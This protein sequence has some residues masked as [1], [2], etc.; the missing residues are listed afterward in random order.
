MRKDKMAAHSKVLLCVMPFLPIERPALG[1]S[2]FAARLRQQG[3]ACDIFYANHR[4]ADRIG[5]PLYQRI[6]QSAPTHDLPGEWVFSRALWRCDALPDE[7]FDTY[8][9]TTPGDYYPNAFL[10]QIRYAREQAPQY[11]DDLAETIDLQDVDIVGFSSTFQQNLASLAMAKALKARAP[12]LHVVFGG[13]NCEGEM[14]LELHRS[15][16]FIDA[17]CRGESDTSFPQLIE[18]VRN[19]ADMSTIG[20]LVYRG[21]GGETVESLVPQAA[22]RDM[23]SLPFP[24]HSDFLAAFERSTA[25]QFIEPELT[26]ETSRGCWWGEKHHCTFCGLNGLGIGYRAKSADRALAE[27]RHLRDSTGIHTFFAT[28]NIVDMRYFTTVFPSLVEDGTKLQLFYE[29]KANLKKEQIG[30]LRRLGTTWMQPGIEHLNTHV[31]KLMDKGIRGIQNVQTLKWVRQHKMLV[32]WNV[33]CGFPG[34]RPE[35]YEE[36]IR[37]MRSIRHLTPPSSF[38]AFRLDRFSPMFDRP[39]DFGLS[40]IKPYPS[41]DLCYPGVSPEARARIAYFFT[42]RGTTDARTLEG[43]NRA[44][45]EAQDWKQEHRHAALSAIVGTD[46]VTIID[47][48]PDHPVRPYILVGDDRLIYLGLDSIQSIASLTANLRGVAPDRA[49]DE[50]AVAKTVQGFIQNDLVLQEDDLYLALAIQV[51]SDTSQDAEHVDMA[52]PSMRFVRQDEA[53]VT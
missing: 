18:A 47:L 40:G 8:A 43:I 46:L 31:L 14:G 29:T 16:T 1:V 38:A 5:F 24:D 9:R 2:L 22:I 25:P 21:A 6:A 28:D 51:P 37:F 53:A 17:V 13:A 50:G 27:F 48:R 3:I 41:Y 36:A 12:N 34:E 19:D 49:W 33:L 42:Y 45:R 35:D 39:D 10:G 4:F 30:I 23:D 15:F 52:A 26:I 11:I 20:G 7:A 44:W 32:T